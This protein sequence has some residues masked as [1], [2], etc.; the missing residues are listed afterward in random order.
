MRAAS[1]S[2]FDDD[3]LRLLRAA[4]LV[5]TLG[6]EVEAET[7][8][9]ARAGAARAGEPSGERQL[10]ELRLLFAA[11]DPVPGLE[12]L[13]SLG[14]T[15]EVLPE[16]EALR[17]VEQNPNHHLD[18]HGHTLEVLRGLLELEGDLDRVAGDRADELAELLAEDLAD[19]FTRRDA[20]RFGA[21]LHDVGKPGTRDDSRGYVTFIGHDHTGAKIVDGVCER[22]KASR[23][24]CAYLRGVTLHHLRLGFLATERPLAP[25]RVHDYLLA[26]EPVSADVTLLTVADRL[27]ARGDGPIASPEMIQAH[28]DL[29]REMLVAALDRRRDGAPRSPIPGD[30][31][32]AELGIE[33]GPELGR[34]IA[35]VEAGVYAGEVDGRDAAVRVARDALERDRK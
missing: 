35:E 17:G 7:A 1:E 4:R 29:A 18:V 22:L 23:A 26:T 33:P 25:R 10:A 5:A 11:P 28:V 6:F 9:L 12:V 21:L 16:V 24:L 8:K 2:S 34:L 27:A 19:G 30:E 3:P 20:L 32:A 31:L 13:D 14:A 15:A